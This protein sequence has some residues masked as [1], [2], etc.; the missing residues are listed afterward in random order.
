MRPIGTATRPRP[1][2]DCELAR[3]RAEHGDEYLK[4]LLASPRYGQRHRVHA[5]TCETCTRLINSLFGG[6]RV[7]DWL[8]ELDPEQLA[9]LREIEGEPAK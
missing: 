8:D 6:D 1:G 7:R 2:P 4:V 9:L 3:Y 5:Q